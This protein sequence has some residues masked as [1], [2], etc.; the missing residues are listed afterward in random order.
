MYQDFGE[1]KRISL[2]ELCLLWLVY[3]EYTLSYEILVAAE[4]LY[5]QKKPL[6][7]KLLKQRTLSDEIGSLMDSTLAFCKEVSKL[8]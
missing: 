2:F 5:K 8:D 1:L 7:Q 3:V 6:S 4:F